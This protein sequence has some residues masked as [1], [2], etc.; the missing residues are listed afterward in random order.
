MSAYLHNYPHHRLRIIVLQ[1]WCR[2]QIP[3]AFLPLL[4]LTF[5]RFANPFRGHLTN[6]AP[7]IPRHFVTVS[8]WRCTDF[9][10]VLLLLPGFPHKDRP[11]KPWKQWWHSPASMVIAGYRIS[12]SRGPFPA[13]PFSL[14][15]ENINLWIITGKIQTTCWRQ[16][17]PH[18][19][20]APQS[21][22]QMS[23]S[24][25]ELL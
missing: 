21:L 16:S 8:L 17:W 15:C 25:P 22:L 9:S 23:P 14:K 2:T 18:L 19:S 10:M 6:R 3:L 4:N 11:I 20:E 1:I 12:L 24:D 13:K 7:E 5:G